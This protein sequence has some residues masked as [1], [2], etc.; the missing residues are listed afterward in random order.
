MDRRVTLVACFL[1]DNLKLSQYEITKYKVSNS[2]ICKHTAGSV[3]YAGS[4][5]V[6]NYVR[7]WRRGVGFAPLVL[8]ILFQTTDRVN[9]GKSSCVHSYTPPCPTL[10]V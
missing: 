5:N 10:F 1:F 3:P 7:F 2:T 9:L 4:V 6:M 8:F